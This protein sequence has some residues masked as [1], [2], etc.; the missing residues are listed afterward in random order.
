LTGLIQR[1]SQTRRLNNSRAMD[2]ISMKDVAARVVAWHNRHPLARRIKP[3]DVSG[4][5]VVTIPCAPSD[6]LPAGTARSRHRAGGRCCTPPLPAWPR[7]WH[8]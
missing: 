2:T 8:A 7:R 1:S 4:I 3:G 5:G 6:A